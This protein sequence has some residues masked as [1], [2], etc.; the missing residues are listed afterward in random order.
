MDDM[1]VGAC[2]IEMLERRLHVIIQVCRDL[3]AK[4]S[5][6]KFKIGQEVELEDT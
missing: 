1:L 3:N 6:R 5:L 2:D 4:L